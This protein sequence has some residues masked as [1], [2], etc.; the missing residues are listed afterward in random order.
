MDLDVDLYISTFFHYR[1]MCRT[2]SPRRTVL[3]AF[4]C[5]QCVSLKVPPKLTWLQLCLPS[6]L[7]FS[8]V[9][10]LCIYWIFEALRFLSVFEEKKYGAGAYSFKQPGFLRIYVTVLKSFPCGV[11]DSFLPYRKHSLFMFLK[12]D[13]HFHSYYSSKMKLSTKEGDFPHSG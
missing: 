9:P 12:W 1:L 2:V 7:L 5:F 4:I 8:S 13:F 11:E 10:L 3:T 6:L